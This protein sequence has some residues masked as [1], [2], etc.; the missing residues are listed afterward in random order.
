VVF[1]NSWVLAAGARAHAGRAKVAHKQQQLGKAT[2]F[3]APLDLWLGRLCEGTALWQE[4]AKYTGEG[5]GVDYPLAVQRDEQLDLKSGSAT[6]EVAKSAAHWQ[7]IGS[8]ERL[9]VKVGLQQ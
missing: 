2:C 6:V 7:G 5:Q 3:S 4:A 1:G 8:L 9:P